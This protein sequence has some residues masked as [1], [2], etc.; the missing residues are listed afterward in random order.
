[1][2][3]SAN[4]SSA[5]AWGASGLPDEKALFGTA[6]GALF[7][8]SRF[9]REYPVDN[10]AGPRCRTTRSAIPEQGFQASG[11]WQSMTCW[12]ESIGSAMTGMDDV[13]NP[14]RGYHSG[15]Q[16]TGYAVFL[17]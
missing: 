16:M 4:S 15:W 8:G 10:S 1:M 7:T 14:R 9:P 3:R 2:H 5:V 12:R 13:E 11:R 6:S 17:G